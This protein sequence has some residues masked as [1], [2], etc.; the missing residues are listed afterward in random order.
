MWWW[1]GL[2]KVLPSNRRRETLDCVVE[3]GCVAAPRT[4]VEKKGCV[5]RARVTGTGGRMWIRASA[6]TWSLPLLS[7]SSKLP[8]PVGSWGRGGG[9]GGEVRC[10]RGG[11]G[12]WQQGMHAPLLWRACA[13]VQQPCCTA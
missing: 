3:Q 11:R 1:C 9:V 2:S 13:R 10:K 12:S 8:K 7:A 5:H 4:H 6:S